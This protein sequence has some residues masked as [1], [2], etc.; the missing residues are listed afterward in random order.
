MGDLGKMLLDH[1]T[2]Y[3]GDYIDADVYGDDEHQIQLLGF[4]RAIEDCIV[5]STLGLSKYSGS[6]NNCC[7]IIMAT[8]EDYDACV[9][10]F[11]NAVFYA[12]QNNMEFGRGVWI[13]GAENISED[14]SKRHDK[15][16]MYF[17]TPYILPEDFSTVEDKCKIYMGFFISQSEVEYIEKYGCEKFEDLLEENGVD[18]INLDREAIL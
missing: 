17:T 3:L 1:Y 15:T 18:V 9:E 7:E 16:A 13:S 12:V 4:D 2:E 6:I 10:F 8:D 5:F 14:F 11:M